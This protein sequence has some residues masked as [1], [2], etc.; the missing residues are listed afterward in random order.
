MDDAVYVGDALQCVPG[1]AAAAGVAGGEAGGMVDRGFYGVFV[2][3]GAAGGGQDIGTAHGAAA[4]SCGAAAGRSRRAA[5]FFAGGGTG[6]F[7][8]ESLGGDAFGWGSATHSVGYA[9]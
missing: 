3:R 6:L 8:F 1:E 5:G 7:E 2:E 4:G 9:D